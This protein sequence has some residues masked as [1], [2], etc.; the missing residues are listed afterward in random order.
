MKKV[1]LTLAIVISGMLA[2]AQD[3]TG[4]VTEYSTLSYTDPVNLKGKHMILANTDVMML[5]SLIIKNKYGSLITYYRCDVNSIIRY[6]SPENL[7]SKIDKDN[8]RDQRLQEL[9]T[10]YGESSAYSIMNNEIWIGMSI[11]MLIESWG[12][13]D[14]MNQAETESKIR[15]QHV[16][17]DKNAYVYTVNGIVTTIQQ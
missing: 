15:T 5:D 13:A 6:I 14:K 17:R 10:K 1:L 2:Q 3:Y 8:E 16:Y 7:V 12:F 9:I 4:M 11:D